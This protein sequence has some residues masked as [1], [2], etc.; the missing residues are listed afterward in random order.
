[1][2]TTEIVPANFASVT[3]Y[4]LHWLASGSFVVILFLE[5]PYAFQLMMVNGNS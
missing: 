5:K 3:I 4:Q 2:R 1:L